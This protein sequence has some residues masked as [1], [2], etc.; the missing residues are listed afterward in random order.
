VTGVRVADDARV[1]T[2]TFDR[3]DVLNAFDTA[4][5]RATADA[6]DAARDDDTVHVVVLTGAG[7]AFS[8]GQDLGEMGKLAA[9]EG[10]TSGF[11]ALLD[12]LGRFDKPLVAAVNGVAIG[13]GFTML[14][15]C[16]HVLATDDARFRAPFAPLGV[17][18]EAA[19]SY[20]FPL[21]MGWQRAAEVLFT[22]EWID[23]QAAVESGIALRTVPGDAL[24]REAHT[25]AAQIAAAPLGSLRAIKQ[26]MLAA[27]ADAI[28]A[29][30][31]REDAAFAQLLS[32]AASR[33]ALDE[34][35]ERGPRSG[36]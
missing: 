12:A 1:R 11:P 16:D 13:V 15:Q 25:L 33:A 27:H 30:R 3:P 28:A 24:L 32:S 2:I 21:R 31:R 17:A 26:T 8:A 20:L 18:P 34:F 6:L 19:S 29:A 14:S 23:A 22:G 10:G 35:N 36:G 5:Y 4:L 9:G 7:R